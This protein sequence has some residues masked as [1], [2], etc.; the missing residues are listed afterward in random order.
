MNTVYNLDRFITA[1]QTNYAIALEEIRRG[2]KISHWMWYI[3]PQLAGL[4][5][6]STSIFYAIDVEEA[7]LFLKHPVLG[8]RLTK[9]SEEILKLNKSAHE[10][11]G[12]PDDIKLLSCMTLFEYISEQPNVFSQVIEKYFNGVR[13][14]RTLKLIS[15]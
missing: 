2:K 7:R 3:F 10:V 1:Q 11:F 13:D 15:V 14:A 4:G 8:M 5:Y 9:I 6:S 12:S